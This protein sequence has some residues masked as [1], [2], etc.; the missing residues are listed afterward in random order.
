MTRETEAA[1]ARRQCEAAL[2]QVTVGPSSAP[3]ERTYYA[4]CVR[5]VDGGPALKPTAQPPERVAIGVFLAV[6]LVAALIGWRVHGPWGAALWGTIAAG[7][8][9]AAGVIGYLIAIAGGLA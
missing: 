9:L 4:E 1:W 5:I 8:G 2:S 7:G 6:V 3:W